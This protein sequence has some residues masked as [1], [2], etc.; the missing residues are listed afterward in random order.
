MIL[1]IV[2]P[3]T[4]KLPQKIPQLPQNVDDVWDQGLS[5]VYSNPASKNSDWKWYVTVVDAYVRQEIVIIQYE[6]QVADV[7]D[8]ART[9]EEEGSGPNKFVYLKL[10]SEPMSVS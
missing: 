2:S 4:P 1:D 8:L 5:K 10:T 9:W 3:I 6:P 7:D